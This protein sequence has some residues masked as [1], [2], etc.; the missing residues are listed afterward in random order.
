M[1]RILIFL[2]LSLFVLSGCTPVPP[3]S[4]E[5]VVILELFVA[6]A[7]GRCPEAKESAEQLQAEYDGEFIVLEAY[8]W[9]YP[10]KGWSKPEIA[11]RY[12]DYSIPDAYF[13]GTNY[14]LHYNQ[15]DLDY[16]TK[17]KNAIN[18]ELAKE[19]KWSIEATV[20]ISSIVK[21]EGYVEGEGVAQVGAAIL[22]DNVPLL[23][24]FVNCVVRD[25][26]APV[27]VDGEGDFVLTA[28]S[29]DLKLVRNINNI[30]VIVF[31]E[32]NNQILQAKEV[33]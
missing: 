17:Y 19:A 5:R 32:R 8:A 31:I 26:L 11:A 27:T 20:G 14:V 12:G 30:R 4:M 25:Y 13:D 29:S 28:Y 7:C 22:E 2:I 10:L 21:I 16:Y 33:M 23:G 6:P 15:S 18:I 9:N 1:K 3:I 24:G